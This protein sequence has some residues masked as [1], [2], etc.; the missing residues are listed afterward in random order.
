MLKDKLNKAIKAFINLL[1]LKRSQ[2]IF[3][4][5]KL[6]CWNQLLFIM[7]S[8]QI[9]TFADIIPTYQEARR[10]VSQK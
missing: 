5:I 6:F 9:E 7:E 8:Y 10:K 3:R 1:D 2:G 4:Q